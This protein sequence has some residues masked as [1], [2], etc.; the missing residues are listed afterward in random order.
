MKKFRLIGCVLAV[1]CL[2]LCLASCSKD[3][4]PEGG[5]G[6][7]SA[8]VGD[9]TFNTPYGYWYLNRE[10]GEQ[11]NDVTMEFFSN[12]PTGNYKSMSFIAIEFTLPEGEEE[13]TST[14]IEGG[15]YHVYAAVDVTMTDEGL[16]CQT[17]GRGETSNSP[18][19]IVREGNNY[20]VS[21]D[22][23]RLEDDN[24]S[25]KFSFKYSGKLTHDFIG[26]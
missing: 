15:Q 3:D 18:L 9:K 4:E 7:S 12:D 2:S 26:E 16:Q 22:N 13:I 8:K 14:V 21:I 11:G 17:P 10:I 1:V 23:A 19:R 25:Y 6:S 24:R 5:N 20:T